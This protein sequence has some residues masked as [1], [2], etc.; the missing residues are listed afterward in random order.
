MQRLSSETNA[1]I[2]KLYSPPSIL[3]RIRRKQYDPC[4]IIGQIAD[5]EEYAAITTL[6]PFLF[7]KLEVAEAASEAIHRLVQVIPPEEFVA[8]DE[9]FR[10]SIEWGVS[11]AWHAL[12]PR[13][14]GDLP[15]TVRSRPA[16]LGLASLHHSG[17]V[18]EE[19]V[20]QL[21][22]LDDVGVIP[23]LL[24][25]LND[26]V[27][28]VR[29]A[30][31]AGIERRMKEGRW[32]GFDDNL[33]LVMRLLQCNRGRDKN[34]VRAITEHL[35]FSGKKPRTA[36]VLDNRSL[37]VRRQGFRLLLEISGPHVR[38]LVDTALESHD[39]LLRVWGARRA[40]ELLSGEELQ[41]CLSVLRHDSVIGVRR[42]ALITTVCR[43]PDRALESLKEA[44]FDRSYSMRDLA[45]Y[46]LRKH[47]EVDFASVYREAIAHKLHFPAVLFGLAE[48]G[49]AAG[50]NILRPFL[51]SN[52]ASHR[53]AAVEG[54]GALG[55][56]ETLDLV[57]PAIFDESRKVRQAAAAI[58]QK[59]I[60]HVDLDSLRNVVFSEEK[61]PVRL[62]ALE[63]LDTAGI[64]E[65]L[66]CLI[67]AACD[68]EDL[69]AEYARNR[70]ERR[71]TR[72][73]TNPSK[74]QRQRIDEALDEFG[75]RLDATFARGLRTWLASRT[76]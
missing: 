71:Y 22:E 26:W 14:V 6:L 31:R 10:C 64:W 23:F 17:Y 2:E 28:N 62:A 49:N 58:L 3:D 15:K 36:L 41:D 19:A 56:S 9:R 52:I 24:L 4:E 18:R 33:Y 45:R 32:E 5:R 69:I 72:V 70:I 16:V 76:V 39:P 21:S 25:R 73:F 38:E 51:T 65:V 54:V 67:Q 29:A 50:V 47:G 1:L 66:P 35:V 40:F 20:C 12:W 8:F 63:I 11:A 37:F 57:Y 68:H 44:L 75:N 53:M 30:A 48:T 74:Q 7:E 60:A 27:P 42:E 61:S 55:E 46:Y 34:L 59:H 43:F 13:K